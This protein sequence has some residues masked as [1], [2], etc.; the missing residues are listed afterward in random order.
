MVHG[1]VD[2]IPQELGS[3]IKELEAQNKGGDDPASSSGAQDPEG[4]EP[5]LPPSA[6]TEG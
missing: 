2:M 5:D 6:L 1:A 3:T 4:P